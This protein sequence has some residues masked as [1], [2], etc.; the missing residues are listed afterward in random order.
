MN[1]NI[2]HD[3]EDWVHVSDKSCLVYY[4]PIENFDEYCFQHIKLFT[5]D[6]TPKLGDIMI[7]AG[8]GVGA[9]LPEFSRLVGESGHVYAIEADPELY[10]KNLKVVKLMKL[11]NV[12]CINAALMEKSG[13]VKIGVVSP[14]GID[15]SIFITN[16][17]NT[18]DVESI[19]IDDLVD[20]YKINNIDYI[21]INIEGAEINAVQGVKDISII[22]NWCI[23]THDFC[24]IKTKNLI[25]NFFNNKGIVIK[26]HEEVDSEP[27]KGG[28]VYVKQ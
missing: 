17:S 5:K 3:G 6:Y 18:I 2:Y 26:L 16:S 7:D 23:S 27:W 22:K 4:R 21:K 1:R 10:K 13:T 24:G 19:S 15:S 12:T 28:Y 8:S 9:E 14:D 11:K 20:K 25:V